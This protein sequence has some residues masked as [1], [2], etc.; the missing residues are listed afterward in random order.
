MSSRCLYAMT[1]GNYKG[2]GG[3]CVEASHTGVCG[4]SY[5]RDG[6]C[7]PGTLFNFNNYLGRS[8]CLW[9]AQCFNYEVRA[10]GLCC[11]HI[12]Y[13]GQKGSKSFLRRQ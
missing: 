5:V 4:S 3:I 2:E 10:D 1:C 7:E 13:C 6:L 8:L 9:Q 11:K 12:K